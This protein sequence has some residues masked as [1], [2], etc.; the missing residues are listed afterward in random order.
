MRPPN[1]QADLVQNVRV[2][3]PD[4]SGLAEATAREGAV[5]GQAKANM[6]QL[7]GNT[8]WSAY[9][10]SLEADFEAQQEQLKNELIDPLKATGQSIAALQ[11]QQTKSRAAIGEA[12]AAFAASNASASMTA[13]EAMGESKAVFAGARSA[14]EKEFEDKLKNYESVLSSFPARQKEMLTRSEAL[15]KTYIAKM[16]GLADSFR[17]MSAR[18]L[19]VRGVE[20]YSTTQAYEAISD[21]ARQR[22]QAARARAEADS[23]MLDEIRKADIKTLQGLGYTDSDAVRAVYSGANIDQ[24]LGAARV[25]QQALQEV[26]DTKQAL[27]NN[28]ITTGV[29]V[30]RNLATASVL[31]EANAPVVSAVLMDKFKVSPAQLA[32]GTIPDTVLANPEFQKTLDG[33]MSQTRMTIQQTASEQRKAL[34]QRPIT[35]EEFDATSKTIDEWEKNNLERLSTTSGFLGALKMSYKV[36]DPT[37]AGKDALTTA[38][39]VAFIFAEM[40]KNVPESV[41]TALIQGNPAA[42]ASMEK[43]YGKGVVDYAKNILNLSQMAT[44]GAANAAMQLAGETSALNN[45]VANPSV[46]DL[47][48]PEGQKKAAYSALGAKALADEL[49]YAS[50]QREALTD[51]QKQHLLYVM[52]HAA[53]DKRIAAM[54]KENEPTLK[55]VFDKLS[56]QEKEI[57]TQQLKNKTD[58][59]VYAGGVDS[60]AS[61]FDTFVRKV[62]KSGDIAKWTALQF[63]D[64]TGAN[65][66]AFS[67]LQR[68]DDVKAM[69]GRGLGAS[70]EKVFKANELNNVLSEIDNTLVTRSKFTGESLIELRKTFIKRAQEAIKTGIPLSQVY[71]QEFAPK[72]SGGAVSG[73]VPAGTGAVSKTNATNK[74]WLE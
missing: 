58:N 23:K 67:P 25:R 69:S 41:V 62:P 50:G 22:E 26:A 64:P 66:L 31:I 2:A 19:G 10:G 48:T 71:M 51:T 49:R 9:K 52:Q 30:S 42:I 17:E 65:P 68:T 37:Q 44:K 12:E 5:K 11:A 45:A 35:R 20:S 8:I 13:A 16:P 56:P 14:I 27:A 53:S 60:H 54:V 74:W 70:V 7:A 47:R 72:E 46:P 63:L 39:D 34:A 4:M 3:S 55:V 32:S 40:K 43:A 57:F 1:Y 18:I 29:A 59:Y 61:G 33:F 38:K 28:G 21:F 6:L 15:L 73:A 24:Q 36:L